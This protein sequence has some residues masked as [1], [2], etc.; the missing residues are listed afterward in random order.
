[1]AEQ[2]IFN[3]IKGWFTKD[4]EETQAQWLPVQQFQQP[5]ESQP[6]VGRVLTR[7][8]NSNLAKNVI[9]FWDFVFGDK[10][11]K[12]WL[13]WE[14][15][16]PAGRFGK[17]VSPVTWFGKDL[18]N[19]FIIY[20]AQKAAM[21]YDF[22][23]QNEDQLKKAFDVPDNPRRVLFSSSWNVLDKISD[24][25][26]EHDDYLNDP[27][28]TEE[29]RTR[30][31]NE[32]QEKIDELATRF[33]W[34]DPSLTAPILKDISDKY[35]KH[36]EEVNKTREKILWPMSDEQKKEASE[37]VKATENIF[38]DINELIDRDD[39]IKRKVRWMPITETDIPKMTFNYISDPALQ[40][41]LIKPILANNKAK[42]NL[43]KATT[44]EDKKKWQ[45]MVDKTEQ[46]IQD[47]KREVYPFVA[48]MVENVWVKWNST[49]ELVNAYLKETGK[50]IDDVFWEQNISSQMAD[51]WLAPGTGESALIKRKVNRWDAANQL[52]SR[53]K[54]EEAPTALA[55][56]MELIGWAWLTLE[57]IG[58]DI[59]W[60][61]YGISKNGKLW[62]MDMETLANID[63]E[64][65]PPKW[66]AAQQ[67]AWTQ[68]FFRRVTQIAPEVLANFI[69]LGVEADVMRWVAR[70]WEVSRAAGIVEKANI[71]A[72]DIKAW[73]RATDLMKDLVVAWDEYQ[74]LIKAGK[75]NFEAAQQISKN[76]YAVSKMLTEI[77]RMVLENYV[78]AWMIQWHNPNTYWTNDF[79]IDTA[80]F[81]VDALAST[82]K[83]LNHYAP[84]NIRY[85]DLFKSTLAK[86]FWDIDDK[87][88]NNLKQEDKNIFIWA[89]DGLLVKYNDALSKAKDPDQ[90]KGIV[91]QFAE[92]YDNLPVDYTI[93]KI[94]KADPDFKLTYDVAIKKKF[95]PSYIWENDFDR[96]MKAPAT[97]EERY[98]LM[99]KLRWIGESKHMKQSN[100][101]I[102]SK[103]FIDAFVNNAKLIKDPGVS[104]WLRNFIEN[105][106]QKLWLKWKIKVNGKNYD[107][108]FYKENLSPRPG[109]DKDAGWEV[110][111]KWEMLSKRYILYDADTESVRFSTKT[112]NWKTV[113]SDYVIVNKATWLP[114]SPAEL[115]DRKLSFY[116]SK[117]GG[118]YRGTLANERAWLIVDTV[119]EADD[120]AKTLSKDAEVKWV[121]TPREV[122]EEAD[123]IIGPQ[124]TDELIN[125]Q[126]IYNNTSTKQTKQSVFSKLKF[127]SNMNDAYKQIGIDNEWYKYFKNDYVIDNDPLWKSLEKSIQEKRK[128][129]TE[130]MEVSRDFFV[131]AARK[132]FPQYPELEWKI[133]RKLEK[134]SYDVKQVPSGLVY[135]SKWSEVDV[136]VRLAW[137][138]SL[139][140]MLKFFDPDKYKQ[141]RDVPDEFKAFMG[142]DF[143][144]GDRPKYRR[145]RRYLG[146]DSA[147]TNLPRWLQMLTSANIYRFWQTVINVAGLWKLAIM[148][149]LWIWPETVARYRMGTQWY[150]NNNLFDF[151]K[152]YNLLFTTDDYS[153][154]EMWLKE[155]S[156]SGLQSELKRLWIKASEMR[157]TWFYN[158]AD[159]YYWPSIKNNSVWQ[160]IEE[161]LPQIESFDDLTKYMDSL[162]KN[163]RTEL[164]KRIWD[165][166]EVLYNKRTGQFSEFWKWHIEF[167]WS[168]A[169]LINSLYWMYSLMGQWW[170]GMLKASVKTL[171]EAEM[172]TLIRGNFW[173]KYLDLLQTSWKEAADDRALNYVKRND[174]FIHL[175]NKMNIAMAM[176]FK[177]NRAVPDNDWEQTL[178]TTLKEWL[179]MWKNYSFP[180][181]AL[182]STPMGRAAL[183]FFE[184]VINDAIEDWTL[185]MGSFAE[186]W[187]LTAKQ[188]VSDMFRRFWIFKAWVY[189][190]SKTM[191]EWW[192][193]ADLINNIM[194][195]FQKATGWYLYYS[196]QE[197]T[198]N[199]YNLYI[200]TTS[201]SWLMEILPYQD[202]YIKE[203]RKLSWEAAMDKVMADFKTYW[204]SWILY[205][206]PILKER[207]IG[208]FQDEE[209]TN[210]IITT[211]ADDNF[212]NEQILKWEIDR[213]TASDNM[214]LYAYQQLANFSSYGDARDDPEKW[215]DNIRK[216]FRFTAEW[217]KVERTARQNQEDLFSVAM[218]DALSE[219]DYQKYRTAFKDA[220]DAGERTAIQMIAYADAA[221]PGAGKEILANLV[222]SERFEL[223]R[224]NK[225]FVSWEMDSGVNK[226]IQKYLWEKYGN[227]M[228]ITDK[229]M[230]WK[231]LAL[232]GIREKHP[233]LVDYLTDPADKNW[234]PSRDIHIKYKWKESDEFD[235]KNSAMSQLFAVD[236][237][238]KIMVNEW[239][240]DGFK[241]ANAF[242]SL[243]M[244]SSKDNKSTAYLWLMMKWINHNLDYINNSARTDEEKH[245]MIA[246]IFD[247]IYNKIWDAA[248]MLLDSEY[249]DD[250]L[251]HMRFLHGTTRGIQ[252]M[253]KEKW[254]YDYLNENYNTS[255]NNSSYASKDFKYYSMNNSLYNTIKKL[256]YLYSPYNSY[257]SKSYWNKYYSRKDRDYLVEYGKAAG[258]WVA[259]ISGGWKDRPAEKWEESG[260]TPVQ[261]WWTARP[262]AA[263][264][265]DPDKP[266]DFAM[267][268]TL[269][270][271]LTRKAIKYDNRR[272]GESGSKWWLYNVSYQGG[273][274]KRRVSRA[275]RGDAK[276]L[277]EYNKA[278]RQV[279]KT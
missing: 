274:R 124:S 121:A 77:P 119:E 273:D 194:A 69:P 110:R 213:T 209:I 148:N 212:Y 6:W 145:M 68:K 147:E 42:E 201:R 275:K 233:E 263:K 76:H 13:A 190:T 30:L 40:N 28:L 16:T 163:N 174:D 183:A 48:W 184:G 199:W 14:P 140:E 185:S 94:K 180:L 127:F 12:E 104:K 81:M 103:D 225:W 34:Q 269:K 29:E 65:A 138:W 270:R 254:Y 135:T 53:I 142:I 8:A 210:R 20:P 187:I 238:S 242:A 52:L 120:I 200:P 243:R 177:Q 207:E 49:N 60:R 257:G 240:I 41:I 130:E 256:S 79:I 131:A 36:K 97:E 133:I 248:P 150:T 118:E 62:R 108:V 51:W 47:N 92:Q 21:D 96:I 249:R 196:A 178:V 27:R 279:L 171:A 176:G 241:A 160:A 125:S 170:T 90:I 192:N 115:R 86:N 50:D 39:Y 87:I 84:D 9:E 202:N 247:G 70:W 267:M 55:K 214:K 66:I 46:L 114:L 117:V 102:R 162:T 166:A 235:Y 113:N 266:V 152:K 4:D 72:R 189:G 144:D 25:Q 250:F 215:F 197:I 168:I 23:K 253:W 93:A 231:N 7:F 205:N 161:L 277:A 139:W 167:W 223:M 91:K 143:P 246:G 217:K 203:F 35:R 259:R 260:R 73:E 153:Y 38:Y 204:E 109:I 37:T 126:K 265:E 239:D 85:Q 195:G 220:M 222:S 165:R 193:L 17:F 71:I 278:N 219:W 255:F 44:P 251:E 100:K 158:A 18:W 32:S 95:I 31:V 99:E 179:A 22:Y 229:P 227:L 141:I 136:M 271:R 155:V 208:K 172:W 19:Q 236:M 106:D 173:K 15:E 64:V 112:Y 3:R 80:F 175:A 234:N 128:L 107:Y 245:N 224:E 226:D 101:I 164:L 182:E 56:G 211:I 33:R 264:K 2:N 232:F 67:R 89:T 149:T 258:T 105:L 268:S 262:F 188:I 11:E 156:V 186:W 181:Q 61:L 26:K 75:T 43:A 206:I 45:L 54:Y 58:N 191:A 63:Y 57:N 24:L 276:R 98:L 252:Q 218:I 151:R 78:T 132:Y 116:K 122:M 261:K 154:D 123:E 237:I 244:P 230:W 159:I 134:L 74:K 10:A 82:A 272:I 169:P 59:K 5:T 216:N 88:W 83:A 129:T 137:D 157:K 228:Y 198:K 146:N 1:M 221:S 111:G